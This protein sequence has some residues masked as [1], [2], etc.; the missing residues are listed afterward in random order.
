[1]KEFCVFEVIYLRQLERADER[2]AAGVKGRMLL[3]VT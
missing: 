1:M 3:R 2:G